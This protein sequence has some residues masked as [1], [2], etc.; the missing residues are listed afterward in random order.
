VAER[1]PADLAQQVDAALR[2]DIAAA[3]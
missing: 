2:E 1:P 3:T